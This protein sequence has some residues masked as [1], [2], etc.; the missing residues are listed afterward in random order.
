MI[1]VCNRMNDLMSKLDLDYELH[2]KKQ[3]SELY[4]VGEIYDTSTTDESGEENFVFL[5][6]GFSKKDQLSLLEDHKKIKDKFKRTY[7]IHS[8]K[9]NLLIEYGGST[10]PYEDQ[11]GDLY[12]MMITLNIKKFGKE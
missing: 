6:S 11:Q 7:L 3:P 8:N 4:W 2:K 12:K 5:L 1:D 9:Y 10:T